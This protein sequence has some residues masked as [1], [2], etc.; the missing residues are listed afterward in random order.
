MPLPAPRYPGKVATRATALARIA[1]LPRPLVFTN[2]VFDILHRGHVAYLEQARGL[3]ASLVVAVNSDASARRLGKGDDR[4]HNAHDDRMAVVAGACRRRSGRAVRRRHAARPDRGVPPGRARQGRRLHGRHHRGRGRDDRAR[5]AFRRDTAPARP[6]DDEPGRPHP[7][8]RRHALSVALL[9]LPD[10][11][12]IAFGALLARRA[13]FDAGFW[14]GVERLVYFVL[15]P[16]LLFR[17]LASAPLAF[18]DALPLRRHRRRL[19]PRRDRALGARA[20]VVPPAPRRLRRLL[21]VRLPLQHLH[22]DRHR[23]ARRGRGRARAARTADR[24]AGAARQRCRR[25]RARARTRDARRA[26]ARAQPAGA[27]L[28]RGPRVERARAAAARASR[29]ASSSCSPPPPCRSACSRWAPACA[30]AA[31][32][33]HRARSCGGTASSSS[34][35]PPSRSRS[36]ACSG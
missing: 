19:H 32:T 12:L 35:C 36:R 34:H 1:A 7:R 13:R 18:A 21:P 26:R 2:G 6:L 9:V 24:R 10:F 33:C 16:A 15:F 23:R 3:G 28:R 8:Q 25:R 27:R 5:R 4:P 22:R 31:P 20:A 30:C 11:L 29:C 14:S 17:A